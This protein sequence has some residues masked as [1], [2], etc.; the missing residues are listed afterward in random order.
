MGLKMKKNINVLPLCLSLLTL[1]IIF[2][3]ALDMR[4]E[5]EG[6]VTVFDFISPYT[7]FFIL[8]SL[9]ISLWVFIRDIRKK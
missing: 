8:I 3:W 6:L 2:Q 5:V 9:A 4:E 7:M 1:A